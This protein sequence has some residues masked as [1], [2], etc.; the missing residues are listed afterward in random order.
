MAR[1]YSTILNF[2]I[3][4]GDRL[5]TI[6]KIADRTAKK[7]FYHVSFVSALRLYRTGYSKKIRRLY[8]KMDLLLPSGRGICWA[9]RRY[10]QK[11]SSCFAAIDLMMD[12]IRSAISKKQTVFFLGTTQEN[13][14]LAIDKLRQ[15]F[16]D[17]KIVGSHHGFFSKERGSDIIQA[18]KKSAP[19]YLFVGMG[20]PHQDYWI[21]ENRNF[22]TETTC[23]SVGNAFDL[24]AGA[25]NRGPVWYR[26][27]GLEGI[28]KAF[29]NP[30]R[31]WKAP[32]LPL[33]AFSVL[34]HT[35]IRRKGRSGREK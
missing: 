14:N 17:L 26:K 8:S 28:F 12:L 18:V 15:S 23:V 6:E 19:D 31:L 24:C 1:R 3:F 33:F 10:K 4:C 5:Q 35:I 2:K 25:R 21:Q 27:N 34:W 7:N 11:L 9:S 22:F 30:L 16:P 29:Q 13:L 32:L 20:H